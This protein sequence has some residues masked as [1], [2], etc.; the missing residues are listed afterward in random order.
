LFIGARVIAVIYVDDIL[1]YA[2][3][4]N[5]IT[6]VITSLQRD[7]DHGVAIWRE[8]DAEGFVGVSIERRSDSKLVLTQT[9]LT[10]RIVKALGL[11]SSFSTAISTPAETA[12]L[13]IG[14]AVENL[15]PLNSELIQK[16][17]LLV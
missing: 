10:K 4:D 13:P 11:C 16:R 3:D 14:G 8:G 12:P 9:G 7:H 17:Y 5:K 2:K 6:K 15:L 1:F